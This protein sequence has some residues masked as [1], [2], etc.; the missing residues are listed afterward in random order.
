MIFLI[1]EYNSKKLYSGYE[2]LNIKNG[3]LKTFISALS[4]E[5]KAKNDYPMEFLYFDLKHILIFAKIT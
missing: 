3:Y 4:K 5:L 1:L 2:K